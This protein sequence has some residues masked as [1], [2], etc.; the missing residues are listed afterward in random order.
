LEIVAVYS[1]QLEKIGVD[2][3]CR[4]GWL[5]IWRLEADLGASHL[6]I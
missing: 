5:A 4:Q 1:E 3:G 2:G 6:E